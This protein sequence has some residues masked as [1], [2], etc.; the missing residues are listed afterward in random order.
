MRDAYILRRRWS[1]RPVRARRSGEPPPQDPQRVGA[2][3]PL[4][5]GLAVALAQRGL[6][7]AH[8][9]HVLEPGQRRL[10]VAVEVAADADMLERARDLAD[11]VDVAAQQLHRVLE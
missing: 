8:P 3:D 10:D 4:G 7:G 9:P 2:A 11:A 5:I 6:Q 1:S